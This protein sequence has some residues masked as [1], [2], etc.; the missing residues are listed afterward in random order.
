M[1][2][3]DDIVAWH[4]E[5]SC[6]C[7]DCKPEGDIEEP[8][9]VFSSDEDEEIGATCDNCHK[10]FVSMGDNGSP[11]WLEHGQAV[12]PNVRWA[13]CPTCNHCEPHWKPSAKKRLIALQGDMTCN[14]CRGEL[15]F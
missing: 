7:H 8:S 15:H 13:K 9:P 5:G 11:E 6:Y 12:S 14:S 10:C 1:A 4:W 2:R 3:F